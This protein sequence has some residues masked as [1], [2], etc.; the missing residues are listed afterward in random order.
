MNH[1]SIC[2]ALAL[3]GAGASPLALAQPAPAA[4]AE[5][6]EQIRNSLLSLIRALVD[7]KVLTVANAERMLREAGIDPALLAGPAPGAAPPAS[8]PRSVVRVPYVPEVVKRELRDEIRQEVLAQARA[9]RWGDPGALPDWLSRLTFSGSVRVRWQ[10]DAFADDNAIG[11]LVDAFQQLPDGTTANT[12]EDRDRMRVRARLG[13]NARVSDQVTAGLR[14]VTNAG[15]DANSPVSTNVDLGRANQRFGAAFD[16]AFVQWITPTWNLAGGRI[17]NP[18]LSTDLVWA[19]DLTMDGVNAAYR[20]RFSLAWSGFVSAGVH[21]IRE[22]AGGSAQLA[23]DKWL[24]AAQVGGQWRGLG[25]SSL[26]FGVAYY[27]YRNYEGQLN[28]AQPPDNTLFNAS[29]PVFRQRGNTMFNI[30][31]QSS[32]TGAQ[33]LGVASK[34]ELLNATVAFELGRFE[35]YRLGVSADYVKNLG[36]DRDEIARRIGPAAA[37]L[38]FDRSGL[39][40]LERPRTRGYRY[41]FQFGHADT[42]RVGQW[43][44]FVG[45]R[46]LERDAVP[47]AFTSGDYRLGGTDVKG[48]FLGGSYGLARNTSV[49]LRYLVGE[50][51]DLAPRLRVDSWF[52]DLN[53]R[54]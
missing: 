20:P 29:A 52:L 7:Q 26:R 18:Y 8:P 44:A 12:S 5:S 33:V 53:A 39:T 31:S 47:D 30:Q 28:P 19:P 22:V 37:D 51:I 2:V 40:A 4:G 49:T 34:F 14:L 3:L 25:S 13:V 1:V 36:F 32:S 15:G 24:Y 10:R 16:L 23:S 54:F 46:Y 6:V 43:Q 48:G 50:S 17:A 11:P 35:P 38:P 41:E 42:D 21:P 27:D 9:E 45:Y